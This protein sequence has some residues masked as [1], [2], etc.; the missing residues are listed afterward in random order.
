M[1]E[2][3][4]LIRHLCGKHSSYEYEYFI[5][6]PNHDLHFVSILLQ[7]KDQQRISSSA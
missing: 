6:V 5:D 1:T 2:V 3:E 7:T 4:R